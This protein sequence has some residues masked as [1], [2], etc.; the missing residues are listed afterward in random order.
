MEV[1]NLA[2]IVRCSEA[3]DAANNARSGAKL[4]EFEMCPQEGASWLEVTGKELTEQNPSK[5]RK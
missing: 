1:R 5:L 2:E 4:A 3:P